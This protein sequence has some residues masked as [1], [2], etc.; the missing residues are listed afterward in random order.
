M[1]QLLSLLSITGFGTY[2]DFYPIA[3]HRSGAFLAGVFTSGD[4]RVGDYTE[5][6]DVIGDAETKLLAPLVFEKSQQQDTDGVRGGK[7][8][9]ATLSNINVS[10]I[11]APRQLLGVTA[12]GELWDVDTDTRLERQTGII[13]EINCSPEQMSLTIEEDAAAPLQALIPKRRVRDLFPSADFSTL[14]GGGGDPSIIIPWGTMYKVNLPLCQRP[15]LHVE[16]QMVASANSFYY[17]DMV[18]VPNYTVQAGDRLQYDI[19]DP[20]SGSQIALDLVTSDGTNLR[21]TG[22]V[23]Q[24][25]LSSHPSTNLDAVAV[26]QWYRREIPLTTLVSKTITF[27]LLACE[28]DT[29]RGCLAWIGNA[30]IVDSAGDLR[31]TIFDEQTVTGFVEVGKSP[32]ANAVGIVKRDWWDYGPIRAIDL[33]IHSAYR[34]TAVITSSDYT[35]EEPLIGMNTLR[36]TAPQRDVNGERAAISA[37]LS[38]NDFGRNPAKIKQFLLSDA[39]DGAGVSVDSVSFGDAALVLFT[40]GIAAEGGLSEQRAAIDVIQ[41]LSFQ[42][43]EIGLNESG[44]YTDTADSAALHVLNP[45]HMGE[46]DGEWENVS[47]APASYRLLDQ[48]KSLTIKASLVRDFGGSETYAVSQSRTGAVNGSTVTT[49]EPYLHPLSVDPEVYYRFTRNSHASLYRAEVTAKSMELQTVKVHD[50]VILHCPNDP[51]LDGRT[52]QVVRRTLS[53]EGISFSLRGYDGATYT[54][55]SQPVQFTGVPPLIDYRF[56]LPATPTNFMV[57]VQAVQ[58]AGDGSVKTYVTVRADAPPTN[59]TELRFRASL[60][61]SV[62]F[63]EVPRVIA[64]GETA[65]GAVFILDPGLTYH[66]E[67]FAYNS[68]N[69]PEFRYSTPAQLLSVVIDGD[70]IPPSAPSSLVVTQSGTKTVEIT[71]NA[72]PPVDWGDT[73]L[74]R[75]TVNNS[76][77]AVLIARG[78]KLNFHDQDI[79]YNTVYYYWSKIADSSGNISAFSPSSGG[80]SIQRLGTNDYSDD[81]ITTPKIPNDAIT[82]TKI[83]A[84]AVTTAKIDLLAVTS[85]NIASLAVTSA[86]IALAAV[87]TA[88]IANLAV[89]TAQIDNLAVTDAKVSNLSAAKITTGLLNVHPVSGGAT[90]IFVDSAGKIRMKAMA[91]SPATIA[92]EDS[93]GVQRGSIAGNAG[94]NLSLVNDNTINITSTSA[95]IGMSAQAITAV[96]QNLDFEATVGGF[97]NGDFDIEKP[98]FGIVTTPSIGSLAGYFVVKPWSSGTTYKVPVYNL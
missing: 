26:N 1:T 77:S 72:S 15:Y 61:G 68:A 24:N 53:S 4:F 57:W 46:G 27:Y 38:T 43:E 42:G 37:T 94:G 58:V 18:D 71:V 70:T 95:T 86:K 82:G 64:P 92:F 14:T 2:A 69:A 84:L 39:A 32:A 31:L 9:G 48:L 54:Y 62:L 44:A 13:T 20:L 91:A 88:Q 76:A 81:S 51:D 93:S 60:A 65:V 6:S 28:A 5:E 50:L 41:D 83:A 7:R 98:H 85:A 66:F 79:V 45:V 55:V 33:T 35:I 25:G 47:I 8:I 73:F 36:F 96:A 10:K 12:T 59:V 22:A 75:S 67:V 34:G 3:R 97:L 63:S 49:E 89:G 78:K 19:R 90:A 40:A 56:T 52:M 29:T 16:F 21:D 74:Y 87:G 80:I 30:R 23:D 11:P 17:L